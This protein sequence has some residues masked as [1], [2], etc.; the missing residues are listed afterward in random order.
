VSATQIDHSEHRQGTP[1]NGSVPSNPIP[2]WR[3]RT[4][5]LPFNE[6]PP[7]SAANLRATKKGAQV[8]T[9][10]PHQNRQNDEA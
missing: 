8:H 3:F 2:Q 5:H 1:L 9:W 7:Q 4:N 10:T 6:N